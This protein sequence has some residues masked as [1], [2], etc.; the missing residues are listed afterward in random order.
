[1]TTTVALVVKLVS[2]PDTQDEVAQ[3][4]AG[5]V[6][7]ANAEEGTPVLVRAAH[8]RL[9]VLD[10]R[11]LPWRRRAPDAPQRTDRRRASWKTPIGSSRSRRRS[12]RPKCWRPRSPPER[13]A[14]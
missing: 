4:L 9:D 6:E 2:K 5:A 10:R 11:R 12:T 7:L 3:F 1:M 14:R 8:R 13:L